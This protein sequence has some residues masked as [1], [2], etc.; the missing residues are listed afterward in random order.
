V[1]KLVEAPPWKSIEGREAKG[2]EESLFRY[3][4]KSSQE[5]DFD[6]V[7]HG[8]N[9]C[10][11]RENRAK[12]REVLMRKWDPIGVCDRVDAQ[13]EYDAYLGKVYVMLMDEHATAEAIAAYLLEVATGRMGLSSDPELAERSMTTAQILVGLRPHFETH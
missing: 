13:D 9:K 5:A 1:N 7:R 12:I 8:R 10:Q 6:V 11:S 2:F 4:R 3:A